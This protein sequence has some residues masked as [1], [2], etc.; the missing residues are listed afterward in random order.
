M[1][2]HEFI[3]YPKMDISHWNAAIHDGVQL[4]QYLMVKTFNNIGVSFTSIKK[5][6]S[7]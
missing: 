6:W 7:S 1:G 4:A 5:Y 2:T 3:G